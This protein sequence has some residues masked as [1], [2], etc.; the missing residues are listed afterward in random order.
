MLMITQPNCRACDFMKYATF[1]KDAV[2]NEINKY[3]IPIIL[4][5]SEL[6]EKIYIRGTP[7]FRFYT[8]S[9][10]R[11]K[12]KLIGGLNYKLFLPKIENL[13]KKFFKK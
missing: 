13:R 8:P 9:G 3:Y 7:T 1:Q 6:T 11:L 12:Y 4:D 10:K 5:K 2:A